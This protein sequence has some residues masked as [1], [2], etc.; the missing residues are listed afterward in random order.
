LDPVEKYL[1][2]VILG[3]IEKTISN[4]VHSFC[5]DIMILESFPGPVEGTSLK[6]WGMEGGRPVC[7]ASDFWGGPELGPTLGGSKDKSE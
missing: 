7:N 1:F 5:T 6:V 4:E 3:H 2:L